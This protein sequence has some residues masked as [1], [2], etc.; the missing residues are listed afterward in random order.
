M[1]VAWAGGQSVRVLD[2]E[3][4]VT[5]PT[6]AIG[7][8][9][10]EVNYSRDGKLLA[11]RHG[12]ISLWDVGASQRLFTLPHQSQ[13]PPPPVSFNRLLRF[14]EQG[15]LWG[16]GSTGAAR[17]RRICLLRS[18]P[19]GQAEIVIPDL[20][21]RV[22]ELSAC[23]SADCGLLAIGA[24][25]ANSNLPGAIYL[26]DVAAGKRLKNLPGHWCQ[27]ALFDFSPDNKR[28]ASMGIHGGEIK[29][30]SLADIRP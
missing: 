27:T 17:D 5:E 29:I 15:R 16:V 13:N 30:W 22:E 20:G 23:M 1:Q 26:W 9:V 6:L 18:A 4:S 19:N 25:P 10:R 3:T 2:I 7:D 28:L 12:P 24:I 21:G 11:I 14:D 8:A